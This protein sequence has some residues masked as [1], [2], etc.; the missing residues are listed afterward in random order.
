MLYALAAPVRCL[1]PPSMLVHVLVGKSNLCPSTCRPTGLTV[2]LREFALLSLYPC[3]MLS[4]T[5]IP[6]IEFKTYLGSQDGYPSTSRRHDCSQNSK[7]KSWK[8]RVQ[9][10]PIFGV[11]YQ[12]YLWC[13]AGDLWRQVQASGKSI[14]SCESRRY[15]RSQNQGTM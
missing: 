4:A 3:P 15:E 11:C 5:G 9:Q 2:R 13:C 14:L 7:L 10:S 6:F 8:S 1:M 12:L